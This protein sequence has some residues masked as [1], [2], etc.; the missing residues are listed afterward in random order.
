MEA[1]FNIIK[2]DGRQDETNAHSAYPMSRCIEHGQKVL[3]GIS[4][5]QREKIRI[6]YLLAHPDDEAT[7][8]VSMELL[9]EMGFQVSVEWLTDGDGSTSADVKHMES[10]R[11]MNEMGIKSYHFMRNSVHDVINGVF[12]SSEESRE[13]NISDLLDQVRGRVQQADIVITNAFE[14]GHILHDLTNLLVRKA[15]EEQEKIMLEIPQ[16]SLKTAL[17]M[18]RSFVRA[19]LS[20]CLSSS[21]FYNV[22]TFRDETKDS[23]IQLETKDGERW[24]FPNQF[25]L[26]EGGVVSKAAKL[27]AYQSQ[28]EKVFAPFLEAVEFDKTEYVEMYRQAKPVPGLWSSLMHF[29]K[30]IMSCFSTVIN[31]KK[32]YEVKDL[33]ESLPPATKEQL[34]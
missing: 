3:E 12:R 2:G 32:L 11:T 10:M 31:P 15:I 5:E 20:R 30:W 25:I 14:G 17:H 1:Q 33:I 21:I 34:E 16:Y 24:V 26:N 13:R 7:H 22:G 6:L 18:T 23:I 27:R 4:R 29:Q 28:W 8:L 19:L 9:D